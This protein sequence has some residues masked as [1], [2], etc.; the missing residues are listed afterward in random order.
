V[1][2]PGIFLGLHLRERQMGSIYHVGDGEHRETAAPV[3]D[4]LGG[5]SGL[6]ELPIDAVSAHPDGVASGQVVEPA[7]RPKVGAQEF[8]G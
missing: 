4:E 2:I 3:G 8:S 5:C 6:P 1:A 7:E